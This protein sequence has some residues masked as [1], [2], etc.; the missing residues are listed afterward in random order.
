MRAP[1]PPRP[2]SALVT[3]RGRRVLTALAVAATLGVAGCG[4]D[5]DDE[6]TTSATGTATTQTATT[7][8]TTPPTTTGSDA[9]GTEAFKRGYVAQRTTLN[10]ITTRLGDALQSADQKTNAQIADELG[11]IE[12]DLAAGIDRLKTLDP[13]ASVSADF[14]TAV[15]TAEGIVR[16]LGDIISAATTGDPAGAKSAT[17]R[18]VGRVPTLSA[19]TKGITSTLGLPSANETAPKTT[20]S[21]DPGAAT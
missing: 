4:G 9:D 3:L 15:R 17:Q 5:S 19:A 12:R 2:T 7:T 16:D 20:T 6:S 8:A 14:G 10:A 13:P 1:D 18:L 11:G 21:A